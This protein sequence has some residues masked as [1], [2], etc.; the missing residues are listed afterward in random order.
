MNEKL[1][2]GDRMIT[3]LLVFFAV[4]FGSLVRLMPV[5]GGNMPVNDG[6]LFYSMARD[7]QTTNFILPN[8]ASFNQAEIPFAYPPFALYLAALGGVVFPLLQIVRWLPPIV[9]II[10]IL[11]FFV[12]SR[13]ILKTD[14]QAGLATLAFAMLPAA[15]ELTIPGGGLTRSFGLL[16]SILTLYFAYLLFHTLRPRYVILTALIASL[17]ILSHPIATIHTVL[18]VIVFWLFWGR[19]KKGT[20]YAVCV[21]LLTLA[22]TAPWWLTV[23]TRHGIDPFLSAMG[24]GVDRLVFLLPLLR[25]N[26]GNELFLDLISVLAILGLISCF[27]RRDYLLPVWIL[28]IFV[29]GRDAQ[30]FTAL[31]VAMAASLG[32][33]DV[34]FRGIR[35]LESFQKK[36]DFP[37]KADNENF[38]QWFETS[39]GAKLLLGFF[40]IY[41]FFNAFAYSIND[42]VRVTNAE[43]AAIHWIDQ[44]TPPDARFLTLTFGDPLN[45][46]FQEW[47]PALSNRVNL[48]VV[49]GYEWLPGQ[50]F[51]RRLDDYK[52]LQPCLVE[53]WNCVENWVAERGYEF[54][55]VYVYR[56]YVGR[57]NVGETEPMLSGWLLE[58]LTSSANYFPVYEAQMITIFAYETE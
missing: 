15:Y 13:S 55:Y 52:L 58:N 3:L 20:L 14:L 36:E 49:Q 24:S 5:L 1:Q 33:T 6:G 25:L 10:T 37:L 57:E 26:L 19:T 17:L 39:R 38:Q 11:A 2:Q 35:A 41:S 27:I 30:T 46:P 12:L 53:N 29:V 22:L 47:L 16:F 42:S 32:V 28:A 54:D 21:A 8:Y 43:Q 31:P 9:S 40:L 51:S 50:Q 18:S 48:T 45:T 23:V 44:N 56:G 7:I 4:L 34:V